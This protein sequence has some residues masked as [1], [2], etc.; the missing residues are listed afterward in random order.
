VTR[1]HGVF[2]SYR[3]EQAAAHAGRIYDRLCDAFGQDAVFMDVGSIGLGLDFGR[4]LDDAVSSCVVMLVLIGP[5][6]AELRDER[7]RRLDD[8]NDFVRQEV[9]AGLRREIP[10]VPVLL[11]GAALP[12]SE[13]LPKG[14]QPLVGR[15]HLR[16]LDETFRSQAQALVEELRP[17]VAPGSLETPLQPGPSWT[18]ELIDKSHKHRVLLVRLTRAEHVVAYKVGALS[19]S[20]RVD[21]VQVARKFVPTGREA[22]DPEVEIKF[23]LDDGDASRPSIFQAY[24][25][26]WSIKRAALTVGG[27]LLYDEGPK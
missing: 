1:P 14:M 5:D 7:G 12:R 24:Y 26:A 16:L 11:S 21:D 4:V 23:E 8:P 13:E 17:L 22:G 3:R 10:V 27:R 2:I 6:W 15:Q 18:A 20:L 9:E 19:A 25:A